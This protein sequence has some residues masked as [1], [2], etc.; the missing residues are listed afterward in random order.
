MKKHILWRVGILVGIWIVV[1]GTTCMLFRN[2]VPLFFSIVIFSLLGMSIGT[3][4][5]SLYLLIE[6]V[7]LHRRKKKSHRNFNIWFGIPL[8]ILGNYIISNYFFCIHCVL[9]YWLGFY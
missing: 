4:I 5:L 3:V 7:V 2:E 1:I 8:F 6:S 9:L